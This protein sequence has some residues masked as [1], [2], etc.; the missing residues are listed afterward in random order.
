MD[1]L[2]NQMNARLTKLK[3]QRIKLSSSLLLS[4]EDAVKLRI[5]CDQIQSTTEWI[6][7]HDVLFIWTPNVSDNNHTAN[8]HTTYQATPSELAFA[9]R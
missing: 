5:I 9:L 8:K 1:W 4:K 7:E 2:F 3:A 6:S